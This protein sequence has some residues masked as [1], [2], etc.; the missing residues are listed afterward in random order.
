MRAGTVQA[1]STA[2][3]IITD[4]V[5]STADIFKNRIISF[6]SGGVAVATGDVTGYNGTTKTLAVSGLPVTPSAGDTFVVL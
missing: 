2:T 4:L 1:G 5:E 3:S 6:Y